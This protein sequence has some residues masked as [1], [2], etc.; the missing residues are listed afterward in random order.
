MDN[1]NISNIKEEGK[2]YKKWQ[3]LADLEEDYLK[4][5][6]K[7]FWL[8]IGDGNNRVFHNAIKI[9]EV[10][11]AIHEV[12]CSDGR[13]VNTKEEIKVEAVSFFEEFMTAQ[14]QEFEG[15]TVERLRELLGFHC[16][17][18]DSE[19]LIREVI[20]EEIKSVLFKMPGSKSP[21]PDGYT[22]EFFKESWAV[23]GEDITVAFQSFFIQGF[24]P[25]GLNST[26]L[27]LIPKKLE[28]KV[29]KDYRPIS[30]CNV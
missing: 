5:K 30:C 6:A 19:K 2:A 10:R 3:R 29:M 7:L 26:I 23:I 16:N 11:N 20:K 18:A 12:Q 24:L 1:P 4:Q 17:E 14:P 22:M 25:K 28:A 27:A 21:G 15:S 9:R 8:E 13:L